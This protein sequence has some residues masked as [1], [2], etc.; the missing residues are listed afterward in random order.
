[1]IKFST[2]SAKKLKGGA[3]LTLKPSSTNPYTRL[4]KTKR[5]QWDPSIYGQV[6]RRCKV[7]SNIMYQFEF[8]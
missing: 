3:E 8:D 5:T 1:M 4:S 7:D 2:I 6:L